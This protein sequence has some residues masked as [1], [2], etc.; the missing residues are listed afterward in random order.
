M[1]IELFYTPGCS[2]CAKTRD[3]LKATAKE[4]IPGV[5]WCELN[6]LDELDH[7]V[8]VGVVTLPSIAIDGQVVFSSLPTTRQFRR[9]LT[10]R[11]TKGDGHGR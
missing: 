7:A 5:I 11:M 6:A 10:R 9:E 8:E 2:Q 4:L 1:R 3:G